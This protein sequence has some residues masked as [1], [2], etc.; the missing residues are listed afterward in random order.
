MR[1]LGQRSKMSEHIS[2]ARA[3]QETP[4]HANHHQHEYVRDQGRRYQDVSVRLWD[5][6]PK[7]G[8]EPNVGLHT[9]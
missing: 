3:D 2:S 6:T 4:H 7:G 1:H 9:F 5:F 8:S